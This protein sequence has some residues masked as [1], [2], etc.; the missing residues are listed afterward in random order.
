[1]SWDLHSPIPGKIRVLDRL[2]PVIIVVPLREPRRLVEAVRFRRVRRPADVEERGI[3]S[4]EP[5]EYLREDRLRESLSPVLWEGAHGLK[6]G[7]PTLGVYSEGAEGGDGPVE[8]DRH[9]PGIWE[10]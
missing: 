4:C 6:L 8:G 7:D 1:M 5:P 2:L 3:I 9:D 10:E